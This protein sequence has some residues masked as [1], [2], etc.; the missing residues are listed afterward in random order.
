MAFRIT[1]PK[2]GEIPTFIRNYNS[3]IEN[4]IIEFYNSNEK[5]GK[6]TFIGEGYKNIESAQG[7]IHNAIK[8]IKRKGRPS[9]PVKVSRD[10]NGVL[11]LIRTDI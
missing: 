3:E 1:K 4:E 10:I 8:R 2:D 6:V 11:W 9:F 7:T 5:Y